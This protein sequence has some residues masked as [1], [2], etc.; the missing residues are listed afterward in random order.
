MPIKSM[1]AD[2][3]LKLVFAGCGVKGIGYSGAYQ[4]MDETGVVKH[5]QVVA[6]SS[7]GSIV[8]AMLASGVKPAKF[9]EHMIKTNLADLSGAPA[10]GLFKKNPIGTTPITNTGKPLEQFIKKNLRDSVT[11]FLNDKSLTIHQ[12]PE[13]ESLRLAFKNDAKRGVRFNDLAI[14]NRY[15]PKQFKPLTVNA[16]EYPHGELKIFNAEQT[17]DVDVAEACRAS[18]SVP[19]LL[20]PK[21]I[22]G[23]AYLDGSV[24]DNIPTDYF[25]DKNKQQTLVFAFGTGNDPQRNI[26]HQALHGSG[27]NEAHSARL[28]QPDRLDYFISNYLPKLLIGLKTPYH[29]TDRNEDVYQRLRR[30][31]PLRTVMLQS[32]NMEAFDFEQSK[33]WARQLDAFGYLDTI[34]YIIQHELHDPEKFNDTDFYAQFNAAF[35]IIYR[36]HLLSVNDTPD[37]DPLWRALSAL[38]QETPPRDSNVLQRELFQTIQSFAQRDWDRPAAHAVVRSVEL[39]HQHITREMLMDEIEDDSTHPNKILTATQQFFLAFMMRA[40]TDSHFVN[41]DM[42][43]YTEAIFTKP[44]SPE[45]LL[46]AEEELSKLNPQ[47]AIKAEKPGH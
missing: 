26:I 3:I 6:G 5:T 16:V 23:K 15:F 47:L 12:T 27:V 25:A 32:Q 30:D 10:W 24:F 45:R 7:A 14:L 11:H 42:L 8:A 9:R 33:R 13:L 28:S 4:A 18:A 31:Y 39:Q 37:D 29:Y 21:V 17:P 20:E 19:I 44:R 43:T 40:A 36:A 1:A 38:E 41:P 35:K 34:Q 22:D 2:A 46:R